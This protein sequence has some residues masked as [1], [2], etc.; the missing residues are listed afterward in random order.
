MPYH[1]KWPLIYVQKYV[2]MCLLI[3][4]ILPTLVGRQ[5]LNVPSTQITS[6]QAFPRYYSSITYYNLKYCFSKNIMKTLVHE[7]RNALSEIISTHCGIFCAF[8]L[9]LKNKWVSNRILCCNCNF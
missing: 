5:I 2:E 4:T 1:W 7:N 6:L 3:P 9:F 8:S